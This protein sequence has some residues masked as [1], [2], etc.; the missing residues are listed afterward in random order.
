LI[1]RKLDESLDPTIDIHIMN[2]VLLQKL[3]SGPQS[4]SMPNDASCVQ[5]FYVDV[6]GKMIEENVGQNQLRGC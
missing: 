2:A 4:P 3:F 6:L 5:F 1:G